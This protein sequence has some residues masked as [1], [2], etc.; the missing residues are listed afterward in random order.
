M[1]LQPDLPMLDGKFIQLEYVM[2]NLICNAIEAMEE[3]AR[4]ERAL[5]VRTFT[6]PRRE[7]EVMVQD[8]GPGVQEELATSMFNAFVTTK[9]DGLGMGLAIC[10]TVVEAHGGHIWASQ[11]P[12]R[13]TAIHVTFPLGEP[14]DE[15]ID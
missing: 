15:P 3:V 9:S 13:G 2:V 11:A 1:D 12:P 5:T 6:N 14:A 4:N 7:I 8:T 10:R